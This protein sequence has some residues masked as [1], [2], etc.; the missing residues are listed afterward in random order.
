VT[1]REQEVKS[2]RGLTMLNTGVRPSHSRLFPLFLIFLLLPLCGWGRCCD[3]LWE[4]AARIAYYHPS[5]KKVRDIYGDGWTDYQLEISKGFRTPSRILG[6][7][8]RGRC[9]T[10]DWRICGG[11]SACFV[12]G[13]SIGPIRHHTRLQLIPINLGIQLFYPISRCTKL[14][15]GGAATYGFLR[16][17]DDS[18]H[19]HEHIHQQGWGGLVQSGVAYS[20]SRRGV[21]GLFVDYLFQ[22]FARHGKEESSFHGSDGIEGYIERHG[23]DMSG[24]KVGLWLGITF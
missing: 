13:D 10:I 24:Y 17:K 12:K 3:A 11:V 4:A 21:F 8:R 19:V 23:V 1:G 2:V 6:F 16:I 9:P 14:F 7:S 18:K 15:V 20:F 5:S 22:N